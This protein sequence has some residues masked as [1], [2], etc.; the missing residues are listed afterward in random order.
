MAE[1]KR[2]QTVAF[3]RHAFDRIGRFRA[4]DI[5]RVAQ[6]LQNLR[7]LAC[8]KLLLSFGL[9]NVRQQPGGARGQGHVAEPVI[10]E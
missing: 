9:G 7:R 4:L 8:L 5:C 1:H 2:T 3:D 10:A 6:R